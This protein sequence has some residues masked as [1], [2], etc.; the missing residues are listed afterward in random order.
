MYLDVD[1]Y[2]TSSEGTGV[3]ST[4]LQDSERTITESVW[5]IRFS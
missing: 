4:K 1:T 3:L 2:V 5:P